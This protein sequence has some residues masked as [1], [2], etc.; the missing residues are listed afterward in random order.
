MQLAQF[1]N[2]LASQVPFPIPSSSICI[3]GTSMTM[4]RS[5]GWRTRGNAGLR[6]YMRRLET[7]P[8][9]ICQE[10][11]LKMHAA[12]TAR[13]PGTRKRRR[14][15]KS[16]ARAEWQPPARHRRHGMASWPPS[17]RAALKG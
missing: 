7:E 16:E 5:G 2:K 10:N 4:C 15:A 17:R 8:I 3:P 6:P 14:C 9:M 13:I 11:Q 1:V 12:T